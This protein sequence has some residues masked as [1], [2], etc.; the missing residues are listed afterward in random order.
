MIILWGIKKYTERAV[1]VLLVSDKC[2]GGKMPYW[3]KIGMRE[4]EKEREKDE[5]EEERYHYNLHHNT[6]G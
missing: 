2:S 5:D 3:T 1:H 6:I 4:R